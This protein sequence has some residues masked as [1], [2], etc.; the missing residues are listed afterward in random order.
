MEGKCVLSFANGNKYDGD[1]ANNKREGKGVLVFANGDKYEG[2]WVNDKR[3]G[4]GVLTLANGNKYEGDFANDKREGKGV[5]TLANGTIAEGDFANGLPHGMVSLEYK[6]NGQQSDAIGG[7]SYNANDMIE[8]FFQG[9]KRHGKCTY[10]FFTGEKFEC[11]FVEG[12]CP[13]FDTRQADVR[14]RAK[15]DAEV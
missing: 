4:K 6:V 11:T 10:T 3:E 15:A 1:F 5:L 13:E 7:C 9:G 14:A 12:R 8:G 2:N